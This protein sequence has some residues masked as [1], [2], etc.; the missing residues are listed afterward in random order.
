[1]SKLIDTET[2]SESLRERSIDVPSK[3]ILLSNFQNSEQKIDL[4]N[5]PNCGGV[6]RLHRFQ[7]G[8]GIDWPANPLPLDPVTHA[9]GLA[10][11]DELIVQ[12]FQNASCN[13]RCW[14]CF[15]PFKHLAA[16]A[17]YSLWRSPA[18]IIDAYIAQESPP[19][20]ID[21]SGGQPDLVP[22]WVPWM[23]EELIK[24]GLDKSVF[25]WSDDNLSGDYFWTKLTDDQRE[26]IRKYTNYA[27][28]A[29]F[30]GFDEASFT[31]NTR[32][33]PEEYR[34][35]FKRFDKLLKFGID[36]YGYATFTSNDDSMIKEKMHFFVDQLQ[37]VH[38]LLPLRTI[39]LEVRLYTPVRARM[40]VDN[41]R[42]LKV[43]Y[44]AIRAWNEELIARFSDDQRSLAIYNVDLQ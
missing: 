24:R 42:A 2:F 31:F 12:V 35:Q 14:Y 27:R 43:Q 23:M 11:V 21:L 38:P 10:P 20:V 7:R 5:P 39:P 41:E 3:R 28:V 33:K 22:E 37:E 18:E 19:P 30:K 8:N 29:C 15:V 13:W 25:L 1:M 36:I 9:L 6:G 40:N 16:N 17:K 4:R 44:D 32:A 34:Y 26:L